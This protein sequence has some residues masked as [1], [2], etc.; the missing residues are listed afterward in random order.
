MKPAIFI[1]DV[2]SFFWIFE[3]TQEHIGTT[4]T[5]LTLKQK[6]LMIFVEAGLRGPVV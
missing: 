3:I 4:D 1:N 6:K 2:S 5:D